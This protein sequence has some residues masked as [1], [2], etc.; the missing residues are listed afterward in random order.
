[1]KSLSERRRF[2]SCSLLVQTGI[3]GFTLLLLR[4]GPLIEADQ[5]YF[6]MWMGSSGLIS[7]A[8]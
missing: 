1:M 3:V 7:E 2:R 5:H 4:G 8:S 6:A